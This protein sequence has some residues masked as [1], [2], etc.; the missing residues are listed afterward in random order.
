MSYGD[1]F[2][3]LPRKNLVSIIEKEQAILVKQ[4]DE[5]RRDIK[6]KTAELLKMQPDITDMDPYVVKLL[7]KQ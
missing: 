1:L 7:L 5:T 4:I 6:T 2:I 3:K